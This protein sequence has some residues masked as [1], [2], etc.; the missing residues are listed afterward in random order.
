MNKQAEQIPQMPSDELHQPTNRVIDILEALAENPD[1]YTQTQ[2]AD[3][4]NAKKST[5]T[6]ILKTLC[7]RGFVKRERRTNC[8]K[9]GLS[10]YLFSESFYKHDSVFNFAVSQ[11]KEVVDKCAE[12]CQLGILS[13]NEVLYIAKVDSKE[14]IRLMS[15][16]GTRLPVIQTALGKALICDY[17][18]EQVIQVFQSHKLDDAPEQI[19]D[20]LVQLAEIRRGGVAKDLGEINEHLLCYAL[21][22][23]YNGKVN[24]ALSVSLPTFRLNNDKERLIIQSLWFAK[25]QIEKFMM[26]HENYI[27]YV[28]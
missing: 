10:L 17:D 27:G 13:G 15:H 8:Y 18:K 20:F 21:P 26:E 7:L 24:C 3:K 19:E 2:L 5:L 12:I 16:I 25:E 28:P 11:M 22:I 1:G 6:P 23:R 14:P 4:I 9:L